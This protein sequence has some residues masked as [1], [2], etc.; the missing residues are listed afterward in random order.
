[1]IKKRLDPSAMSKYRKEK[2]Y[3]IRLRGLIVIRLLIFSEILTM[4]TSL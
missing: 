4:I 1:M 3:A 2:K